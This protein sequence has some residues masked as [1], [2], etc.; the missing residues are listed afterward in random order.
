MVTCK[1]PGGEICVKYVAV[2][3][4]VIA[5]LLDN[6]KSLLTHVKLAVPPGT[7]DVQIPEP[8]DVTFGS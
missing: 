3:Q 8:S 2:L 5:E 4:A 7:Q 6:C 1:G